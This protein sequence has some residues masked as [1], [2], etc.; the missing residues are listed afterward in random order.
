[1]KAHSNC[2]TC[3]K[4]KSSELLLSCKAIHAEASH[5]LLSHNAF[6]FTY[7]PHLSA[8]RLHQGQSWH[9]LR[10]LHLDLILSPSVNI[11]G[12][13][14]RA[15]WRALWTMIARESTGLQ[16]LDV[17]IHVGFPV[18]LSLTP[19]SDFQIVHTQGHLVKS[20]KAPF[21][22]QFNFD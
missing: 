10:L 3:T 16:V 4:W 8:F 19:A 18:H 22:V 13:V 15:A 12:V 2:R 20:S 17:D 14:D 6:S 1:M 11:P 9:Y 21:T 7:L 5:F